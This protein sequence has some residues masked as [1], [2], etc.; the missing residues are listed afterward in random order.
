LE[1]EHAQKVKDHESKQKEI[2]RQRQETFGQAFQ[3]DMEFYRQTQTLPGGF[4][5]ETFLWSCWQQI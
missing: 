1:A 5:N 2:L 4:S 3:E